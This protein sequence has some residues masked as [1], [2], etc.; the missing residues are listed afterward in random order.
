M[1]IIGGILQ[2]NPFFVPPDQL[3]RELRERTN[4]LILAGGSRLPA[5]GTDQVERRLVARQATLDEL[6]ELRR[7]LRDL[8][9][10]SALQAAWVGQSPQAIVDSIADALLGML[11]VDFVY[12]RL[13]SPPTSEPAVETA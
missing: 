12:V 9:T 3:L 1:G 10:L 4:P 13:S 11:R 2:Q 5:H 8:I 7:Y 6:A